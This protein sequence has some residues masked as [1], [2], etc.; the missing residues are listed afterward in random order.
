MTG[1]GNV[2]GKLY[3]FAAWRRNTKKGND[4]FFLKFQPPNEKYA[5]KD[6]PDV[7]F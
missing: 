6:N 5:K 7:G 4:Y 3:E 2:N 1:K